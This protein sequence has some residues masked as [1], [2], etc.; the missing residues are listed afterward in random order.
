MRANILSFIVVCVAIASF[1]LALH[2]LKG[3]QGQAQAAAG[4]VSHV[5]AKDG[6][7][8]GSDKRALR[9][10]ALQSSDA[11]M[12]MSGQEVRAILSQPELV[13]KDLPTVIWQYRNEVCVLDVYF[14]ASSARVSAQ[15]VA[16]YEV[17]ARGKNVGN[18][19]VQDRCLGDL[20]RSQAGTNLVRVE[21]FYKSR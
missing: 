19:Q 15:P 2:E 18:E 14:A 17:R 6:R 20:V 3:S 1:F 9:R 21:A 11:L 10:A 12:A 13:R 8:S 5:I 16:H 7:Y 4:S